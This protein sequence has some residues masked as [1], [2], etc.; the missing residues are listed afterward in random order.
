M[1]NCNYQPGSQMQAVLDGVDM[2]ETL[3]LVTADHSHTLSI[4]GYPGRGADI[5]GVEILSL[6][7]FFLADGSFF[8]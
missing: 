2:S 7:K 4:G 8:R 3:V 1:I 6:S 5:T